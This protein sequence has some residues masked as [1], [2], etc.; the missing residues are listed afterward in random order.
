MRKVFL[1]MDTVINKVD[2]KGRVS[3]P[4]DYRAIVKELSTEIVCYRSL[5]AP[6]IEG[7][8]EETL[9]KLANVIEDATDFF[10]ETQ[11]NL[12]NLIFGDARRFTFDSTGRIML[13]EKLL[14]HAG[15][16]DTAVF[17][18]KGRKFQIWNPQN[19]A[20][21]EARIRAEVMKNRP[22]LKTGKDEK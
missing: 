2:A 18:G 8:L 19:W 11:D 9:D 20:K 12:T 6:C 7:C 21:E 15:I 16:T 17:V 13:S 4:A 5:S 3:L 22:V 10:S 1:F 14:K